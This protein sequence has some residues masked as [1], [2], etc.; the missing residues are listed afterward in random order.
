LR[1]CWHRTCDSASVNKARYTESL[2]DKQVLK[3][4]ITNT[5]KHNKSEEKK[6]MLKRFLSISLLLAVIAAFTIPAFAAETPAAAPAPEK[7]VAAEK[8]I[9][10]GTI[11][12][13]DT[14]EKKITIDG[15]VYTLGRRAAKADV[16]V[17]DVV[18]ATVKDGKVKSIAKAPATAKE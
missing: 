6:T 10:K 11:E 2:P 9:V 1:K 5:G 17:G 13:L 12:A 15:T 7:Q 8:S 3:S 4:G 14:K 16:K 18:E